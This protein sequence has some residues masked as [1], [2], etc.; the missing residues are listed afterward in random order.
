VSINGS[1]LE[2]LGLEQH[3]QDMEAIFEVL[4]DSLA[5]LKIACSAR[6]QNRV[7]PLSYL[8][9]L[10]PLYVNRSRGFLLVSWRYLPVSGEE[11]LFG[12]VVTRLP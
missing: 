3:A 7:A 6:E 8:S 10:S 4:N 2:S 11:I 9:R 5:R 1:R 12:V